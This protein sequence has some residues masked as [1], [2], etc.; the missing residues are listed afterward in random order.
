MMFLPRPLL[1]ARSS[2]GASAYGNQKLSSDHLAYLQ[3]I[4]ETI[5]FSSSV[6]PKIPNHL[7]YL[8]VCRCASAPT[9]LRSC[10]QSLQLSVTADF[11]HKI[12][13]LCKRIVGSTNSF[14]CSSG[15][16]RRCQVP[17]VLSEMFGKWIR[18]C[19]AAS[20]IPMFA[21][22]MPFPIGP[23]SKQRSHVPLYDSS[24]DAGF[25]Q[26]SSCHICDIGDCRPL[27]SPYTF[28]HTC[29]LH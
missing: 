8:V 3:E 2:A 14:N 23:P 24:C 25:F 21:Q 18:P 29:R 1:T 4:T 17:A 6:P 27:R 5:L 20:S 10:M 12:C 15:S 19:I 11:M 28:L 13:V 7:P 22:K 9:T 16:V 26:C